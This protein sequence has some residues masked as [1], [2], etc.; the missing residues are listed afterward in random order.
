[1]W[2]IIKHKNLFS[3]IKLGKEILR[4]GDTKIEKKKPYGNKIPIF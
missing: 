3:H 4:F 2:N 1:M